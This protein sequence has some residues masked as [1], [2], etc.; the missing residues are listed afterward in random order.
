VPAS[1][2][3]TVLFISAFHT[4]FIQDDIDLLEKHFAVRKKI[5]HGAGAALGIAGAAF[6]SDLVFC[7]FASVYAFIGVALGKIFGVKSVVVVGGVDVAND[8]E[9]Q[10]GIWLS[11]WRGRLVRFAL[12]SATRVLVVDPGL[13]DDAIRLAE[14]DGKNI[15]YLPTGYNPM[16]WKPAG[17]KEPEVLT[18]AVV[19]DRSRL[20]V[21]GIDTLVEAARRLP[22]MTFRVIG[23]DP[24]FS[25]SLQPPL[26]VHFLPIMPRSEL[27]PYY[28]RAKVYCQPSLREGLPNTLCEAMLCGCVPVGSD[29]GGIRT[30]VGDTGI[31][32]P[33]GDVESLVA[34]LQQAIGARDDAGARARARIV[35]LFPQEKREAG[36]V[37]LLESFLQ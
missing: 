25:Q 19:N 31:L 28:Q 37:S 23:V 24:R 36:L 17:E 5:G 29:T 26:N 16:T 22:G 12:R 1:A 14:Y 4:P 34:G 33:P 30:A 2:K 10:Y 20:R 9:L 3:P 18:I 13:K 15:Q 7:W 6:G 11:P 8:K 32:I 35:A 21:K 27:L